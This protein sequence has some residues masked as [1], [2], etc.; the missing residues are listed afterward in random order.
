[1]EDVSFEKKVSTVLN[2]LVGFSNFCTELHRLSRC[3]LDECKVGEFDIKLDFFLRQQ[4][5][6]DRTR[7]FFIDHC[8][9]YPEAFKTMCSC[10][11]RKKYYLLHFSRL[12]EK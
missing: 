9:D 8:N 3:S 11:L 1:M 5:S 6:A 2:D 12:L 10:S 4:K 7:E